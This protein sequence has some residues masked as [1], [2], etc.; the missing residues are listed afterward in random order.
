[1]A[2]SSPVLRALVMFLGPVSY[3]IIGMVHPMDV[4]L[5]DDPDFYIGLHIVQL[6][7]IW[8]MAAL[9]WLLTEGIESKAARFG[10]AMILPY[11]IFY[12]AFDVIAGVAMGVIVHIANGAGP[13]DH[14]AMVRF[15]DDLEGHWIGVPFYLASGLSW[16][17]AAGAAIF[18]LKGRVHT[19]ALV[20]L[21]V[22]SAIFAVGHPFP[23]GPVGMTL[24]MAGLGW[25]LFAPKPVREASPASSV[26][27]LDSGLLQS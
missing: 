11:A 12:T 8:A 25:F 14:E 13:A 4:K 3:F 16:L 19:G 23:P 1:M 15:M 26:P 2:I 22:G 27:A 24:F 10:R 6:V 17:L 18:A 21:F 9:L 20:L 7:S 5:G